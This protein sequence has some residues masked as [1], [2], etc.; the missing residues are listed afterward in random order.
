MN[1][2]SAY[3]T[4]IEISF[5]TARLSL[6][7]SLSSKNYATLLTLLEKLYLAMVELGFSPTEG[8]Y[9]WSELVAMLGSHS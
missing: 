3:A 7:P 1:D 2:D 9:A 6:I 4:T 5:R 8:R